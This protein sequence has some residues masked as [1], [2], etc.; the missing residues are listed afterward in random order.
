MTEAAALV[1]HAR[2]VP[3]AARAV[4]GDRLRELEASGRIPDGILLETCHRVELLASPA[5]VR[6]VAGFVPAARVLDGP[7]TVGHVVRLAVGLESAV[8]GEDQVLHQLR[9]A[10]RAARAARRLD[11]A[12]DRLLDVALRAGR[13]ARSWLPARRPTLADAALDR[14]FAAGVDGSIGER[15]RAVDATVLVVGAGSMGRLVA[16]AAHARG[17]RLI[18]ASRT[19]ARAAALAAAHGAAPVAFDPGPE[20]LRDVAAIV[21]ALSGPWPLTTASRHAIAGGTARVVDLSSPPALPADVASALGARLVTIDDLAGAPVVDEPLRTRLEALVAAT[22]SDFGAWA[23]RGDDRSLAA[24]L[25][26]RA[27]DVRSAELAALWR[28][29]PDLDPGVR[30]EI[31]RMA[32]DLTGRLLR[33]PLERL[34]DDA[35][36]GRARVAREL[37]RL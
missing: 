24:A 29:M 13:R 34:G 11:P 7:A 33:D 5:T 22:A 12:L 19:P 8:V 10:T 17:H 30:A 25:V 9:A 6:A 4:I 31:E 18:V 16:A 26:D 2:F 15:H 14:A 20:L 21:G 27:A 23:A 1:A 36:G 37:F 3:A 28:R 32:S 35:D